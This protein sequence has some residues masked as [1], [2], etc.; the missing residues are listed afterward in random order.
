MDYCDPVYAYQFIYQ[1]IISAN[2]LHVYI[3][4]YI[5]DIIF[6][7]LFYVLINKTLGRIHKN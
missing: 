3:F 1:C 4:L 5:Q 6:F 2:A 7:I